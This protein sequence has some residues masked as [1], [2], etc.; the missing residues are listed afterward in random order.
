MYGQYTFAFFLT[1]GVQRKLVRTRK[2]LDLN[3]RCLG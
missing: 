3:Q 1:L 2:V